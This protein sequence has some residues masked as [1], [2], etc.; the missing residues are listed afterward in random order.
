MSQMPNRS[1]N[2]SRRAMLRQIAVGLSVVSVGVLQSRARAAD[3]L[4]REQ[5]PDA[6][7]VQYTEDAS[8]VKEAQSSGQNCSNCSV[9]TA[10]GDTQGSCGL[11]KGKQVKAAGWCNAWSGL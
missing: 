9:Y 5:D 1:L 11:F 6:K 2:G 3:P 10:M 7:K 8:R 4:L